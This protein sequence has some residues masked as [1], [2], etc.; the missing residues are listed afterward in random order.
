MKHSAIAGT[1]TGL[2]MLVAGAAS[3]DPP[4]Y[5]FNGYAQVPAS[6]GG[7]LV[8]RSVLT[9]NGVVPTP[10]PLDFTNNQYTLV[11]RAVLQSDNGTTQQYTNASFVIYGDPIGTGTAA[12]YGVPATF[13][14][15]AP[16]FSA[17]LAPALSRVRFSPSLGSFH[18]PVQTP[19]ADFFGGWSRTVGGIPAGYDENWDGL[20]TPASVGVEPEAWQGVKQLYR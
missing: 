15:G 18:G 1:V 8:M 6:V 17:A 9:N 5:D 19:I 3:A 14:D 20:V 16:V 10:I 12:D 4:N 2:A 11:L 7:V 13:A